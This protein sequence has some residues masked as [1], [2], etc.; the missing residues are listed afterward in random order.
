MKYVGLTD[1]PIL[2]KSEHG[3][4]RDWTQ[5][6]FSSESEA[7]KWEKEMLAKPGYEGGLNDGRGWRFGYTYTIS[8]ATRE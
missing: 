6:A 5:V 7:L 4:P 1:D 3:D 8:G 2:R